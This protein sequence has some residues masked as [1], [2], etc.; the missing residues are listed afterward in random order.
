MARRV[1]GIDLGTTNICVSVLEAGRPVVIPNAEGTRVTPSMVAY[2]EKGDILVGIPA[3][4]QAIT[5][6]YGTIHSAKR[7][8]GLRSDS[9]KLERLKK[10]LS[11]DVVDDDRG[12]AAIRIGDSIRN[13]VE[14]S[15]TLL[16][17]VR[18]FVEDYFGEE[19]RDAVITCPAYFDEAQ[20]QAT[21]DAGLIA[22]FN[23]LRMINE[24][25]AAAL[26]YGWGKEENGILVVY[27]WGG[28]TFDCS[29]VESVDGIFKVLA[30]RG[31]PFLGGNDIDTRI[32]DLLVTR[33]KAEHGDLIRLDNVALQRLREAAENA[34][35]E[36][37]NVHE[38]EIS[39]PFIYADV[40]GP[41]HLQTIITRRELESLTED[42]VEK[43]LL[44]CTQALEDANLKKEDIKETLLVGGTT[45]M[46][47]VT[48]KLEEFFGT[49][50]RKNPNSDE[51]VAAGAAI[52]GGI[53]TGDA[54]ETLLL[55]VLPL[56]LGVADGPNFI[57]ILRRG[58]MIPAYRSELFETT[59]DFQ[60]SVRVRV[61]QGDHEK[62]TSNKLIGV[63]HLVN[64][65]PMRAGQM[66]I[67]VN[68]TVDE[69]GLL[70]VEA[71]NQRTGI[72]NSIQ[73][74]DS[75]KLNSR[76]IEKLSRKLEEEM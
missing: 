48:A 62:I 22:G 50:P 68:F 71:N 8:L 6:P 56:S 1:I 14:I 42:F 34:K 40:E 4:R 17:S 32:I 61:F 76:E 55:D 37:S 24:P 64:L 60:D 72:K 10:W 70:Q 27:D 54:D 46:P 15:A 2:T 73:I 16:K 51:C 69:N 33:F 21:N 59:R 20:R 5:N 43:T 52:Q 19:C 25:T 45:K 57:P 7:L 75:L 58:S 29:I 30:T 65:P 39:L 28:G 53:L 26:S 38:T 9:D 44:A 41:K 36:L 3:R 66:K 67:N 23:V 74:R 11:Y 47:C 18:T 35:I 13:P 63:F 12:R 49:A 31:D